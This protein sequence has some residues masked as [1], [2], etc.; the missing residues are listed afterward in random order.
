MFFGNVIRLMHGT[1]IAIVHYATAL[2][3]ARIGAS[4]WAH[5][6]VSLISAIAAIDSDMHVRIEDAGGKT[7]ARHRRE[8]L[9]FSRSTAML[10]EWARRSSEADASESEGLFVFTGKHTEAPLGGLIA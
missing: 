10:H 6:P 8:A 7:A 2:A 9:I 1:S 4:A 5:S 3:T